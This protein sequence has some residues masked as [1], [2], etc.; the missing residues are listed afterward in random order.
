MNRVC[1]MFLCYQELIFIKH[2]KIY[3]RLFWD[4]SFQ[5]IQ[6]TQL[7][8]AT[9]LLQMIGVAIINTLEAKVGFPLAHD[10]K[11]RK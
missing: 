4:T 11:K 6:L 7:Q 9:S 8:T 5:Q 10:Q 1:K 3:H 2:V